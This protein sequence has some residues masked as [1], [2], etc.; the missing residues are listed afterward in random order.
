M[1]TAP[2]LERLLPRSRRPA[3]RDRARARALP[4][5][6]EHLPELGARASV[7]LRRAQRRDQHAARQRQLDAR[8]RVAARIGALRRRPREGAAGHPARRLRHRHVRQRARA[9]RARGPLAAARAD[10]DD[11]GVVRGPRRH[12]R[13]AARL[14]RI[15]PVPDGSVGRAGGDRV[16]RRARDRRDARPQRPAPGPLVRDGRRLGRARLRS[17]RAAGRAVEH[18]A[19]GAAAAGQALPRRPRAGPDRPRRRGQVADRDEEAVRGVGRARAAAAVGAAGPRR[20][21]SRRA[22][23]CARGSC[24][25]ATRRR[26]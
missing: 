4:L 22:S 18:R 8:A 3:A 25:S 15:P 1:L 14:L 17:R 6:D 5:L 16:H 19:Q 26:T 24:S 12:D 10:D 9:A 20:R 11:P 13:G 7:P 2:Q 21:P 23:R